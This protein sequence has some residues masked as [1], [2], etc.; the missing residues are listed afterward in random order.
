M[1]PRGLKCIWDDGC[2]PSLAAIV[3]LVYPQ[4]EKRCLT[5]R[6]DVPAF[7]S[8]ASGSSSCLRRVRGSSRCGCMPSR[9]MAI[10]KNCR[11]SR[12]R[13][14]IRRVEVSGAT[15]GRWKKT[16]SDRRDS[17]L[18]GNCFSTK[19]VTNGSTKQPSAPLQGHCAR[20]TIHRSL[21]EVAF[22][23]PGF[24]LG[25]G[26]KARQVRCL[27]AAAEDWQRFRRAPGN[28][29]PVRSVHLQQNVYRFGC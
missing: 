22:G 6:G 17:S 10:R 8:L 13:R 21:A 28:G 24:S 3:R 16:N 5:E 2:R 18:G 1:G 15:S 26:K 29:Q 25:G 7:R 12:A 14:R 23:S 19:G 9:V 11:D 4:G 20:R 27:N